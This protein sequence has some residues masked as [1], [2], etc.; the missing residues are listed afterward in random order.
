MKF[1]L[2]YP[3]KLSRKALCTHS[4]FLSYGKFNFLVITIALFPG[5]FVGI[6]N[7][8]IDPY[9][10]LNSPTVSGIN[11]L[12]PEQD[13]HN[14]L[15]KSVEVMRL[16]P[17]TVLLGSSRVVLGLNPKYLA[18]LANQPA[19]NLGIP[20]VHIYEAKHYFEHAL[21][22]Q[23]KLKQVIIGIDFFMFNNTN[24]SDNLSIYDKN[25]V[26]KSQIPLQRLLDVVFSI[27]VFQSSLITLEVNREDLASLPYYSNGMRNVSPKSNPKPMI[28]NFKIDIGNYLNNE[29]YY[30]NYSLT[31]SSIKEFKKIIDIC[32]Q[33]NIQVKV[34]ISPEHTA[35]LEAIRVAGLWTVFEEWKRQVSSI[36]PVWDFSNLNK[37]TTE[38]IGNDMKYFLDGTHYS[39]EVG[40]LILNDVLSY[41]Q[42]KVPK[43]F[44]VL[45]TSEN[46]ELHLAKT[47]ADHEIWVK[48][49]PDVVKLVQDLK[50]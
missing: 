25:L 9:G 29:N 11:R 21:I 31:Q 7:I 39:K 45:I 35:Q 28:D 38:A 40:D 8:I 17:T 30:K 49:N 20:G 26:G 42:E 6:F 43:G 3:K 12:K 2:S 36:T 27:Q 50:Q 15:F 10:V 23:P 33:R 34:F 4:K 32:K 14:G 48:N 24:F 18:L 44:G 37:I 1:S 46:I 19:Y 22:N 16:K 41:Q 13:T 5:F 47:R